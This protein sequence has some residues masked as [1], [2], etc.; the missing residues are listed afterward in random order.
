VER[1]LV[2]QWIFFAMTELEPAVLGWARARREGQAKSEFAAR[3]LAA[4]QVLD[5]ALADRDWLL[6][7]FT[8]TDVIC[9]RVVGISRSSELA[10]E[11]PRVRNYIDRARS[12]PAY[13]R[14]VAV[15]T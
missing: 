15:G 2:Y 11:P 12:R 4:A 1:A 10:D 6:G 5:S 7:T 14:A 8:V 9:A 3:Y 13:Q